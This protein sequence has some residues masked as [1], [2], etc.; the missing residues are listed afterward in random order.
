VGAGFAPQN[1]LE[2]G[3]WIGTAFQGLGYATEAAR[4]VI[5]LLKRQFAKRQIIAECRI[6]NRSSWHVLEKIGFKP[7]DK[8]GKR[9]GRQRLAL[10][11]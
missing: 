7:T 10:F 3:Y 8:V 2:I 9:P 5:D 4:A 6:D 1:E 11:S